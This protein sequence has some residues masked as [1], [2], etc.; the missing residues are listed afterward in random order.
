M[1]KKS[2]SKLTDTQ[3]IK[4][5]KL[6]LGFAI[7]MLIIMVLTLIYTLKQ[8]SNAE[9]EFAYAFIVPSILG[10]LTMIPLLYSSAINAETKKRRK[11]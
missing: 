7:G 1:F 11:Q 10:P 9:N 4:R 5:N 8:I 6:V 3:L 2:L